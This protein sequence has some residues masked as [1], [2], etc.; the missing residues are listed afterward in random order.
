M[1]Q[2]ISVYYTPIACMHNKTQKLF[3]GCTKMCLVLTGHILIRQLGNQG[4]KKQ[5]ILL[6]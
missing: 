1:L 4:E 3:Q 6:Y 5:T 2:L